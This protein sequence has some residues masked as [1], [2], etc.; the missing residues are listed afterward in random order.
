MSHCGDIEL[1][2]TVTGKSASHCGDIG[3]DYRDLETSASQ[4]WGIFG[5]DYCDLECLAFHQG[6][7]NW[8]RLLWSGISNVL[9]DI[10][11]RH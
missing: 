7:R 11:R 4:L 2:D 3:D 5:D 10:G 6:Q 9:G 8:R 1:T